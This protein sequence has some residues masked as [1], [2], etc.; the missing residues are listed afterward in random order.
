CWRALVT[1]R[2]VSVAAPAS[3]RSSSRQDRYR[4]CEGRRDC[5]FHTPGALDPPCECWVDDPACYRPN[6]AM[7][8]MTRNS[9]S[10]SSCF[11]G[12]SLRGIGRCGGLT[13]YS[14]AG[15]S[16]HAVIND[17]VARHLLQ[18]E[19]RCRLPGLAGNAHTTIAI[20]WDLAP[21]SWTF[22]VLC[23]P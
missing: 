10:S 3:R 15:D 23:C 5:V 14:A 9:E 16:A 18:T 8:L 1:G 12:D 22:R 21:L 6:S 4:P 20:L 2:P 11:S 7:V 17:C 13:C 19:G